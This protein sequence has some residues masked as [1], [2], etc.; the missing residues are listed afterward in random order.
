MELSSDSIRRPDDDDGDIDID[1]D[2]TGEQQQ[3]IVDEEM[4]EEYDDPIMP[5]DKYPAIRVGPEPSDAPMEDQG[6]DADSADQGLIRKQVTQNGNDASE[7]PVQRESSE[8][9]LLDEI[10]DKIEDDLPAQERILSTHEQSREPTKRDTSEH[11]DNTIPK[12]N[13][14]SKHLESEAKRQ[15][16]HVE[17]LKSGE[18]APMPGNEY[19]SD[20]DV[21]DSMHHVES[22]P[23][24]QSLQERR[25]EEKQKIDVQGQHRING[26]QE[27]A[28]RQL[29]D[30]HDV[31][32]SD[33]ESNDDPPAQSMHPVQITYQHEKISLFPPQPEDQNSNTFLLR[34]EALA[35]GGVLNLLTAC[36]EVLGESIEQ[37]EEL[38][39]SIQGLDLKIGEVGTLSGYMILSL[40][41]TSLGEY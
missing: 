12:V 5:H 13:L 37:D 39:I 7:G 4:V 35:R 27:H 8:E 1:L 41:L 6:T 18:T 2:L 33:D 29:D 23:N 36:R 21:V 16:A 26:A 17:G 10:D 38:E 3:G 40:S 25:P 9:D 20:S 30:S 11:T 34:D 22:I 15:N 19:E 32:S 14:G 31:P 24:L 28:A